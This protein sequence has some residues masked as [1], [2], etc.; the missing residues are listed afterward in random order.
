MASVSSGTNQARN[1]AGIRQKIRQRSGANSAP[2]GIGRNRPRSGKEFGFSFFS[3]L[4]SFPTFF[5][6]RTPGGSDDVCRKRPGTAGS[7]RKQP[8]AAGSGA[9]SFSRP[10][11]FL[12]RWHKIIASLS[13][14]ERK[15]EKEGNGKEGRLTRGRR[16]R[17]NKRTQGK[18]KKE[19]ERKGD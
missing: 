4:G 11:A 8:K 19:M 16:K 6:L 3:A 10:R 15:G 1:P 5:F 13:E 9:G 7:S 14:E 17:K 2:A 18:G 12:P